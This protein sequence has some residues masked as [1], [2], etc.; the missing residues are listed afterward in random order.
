MEVDGNV[1][2]KALKKNNLTN[3]TEEMSHLQA[4]PGNWYSVWMWRNNVLL[5]R[6]F[7]LAKVFE[8]R[9]VEKQKDNLYIRKRNTYCGLQCTASGLFI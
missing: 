7:T 2:F 8:N 1:C 6:L 3:S 9:P 4:F 5:Q